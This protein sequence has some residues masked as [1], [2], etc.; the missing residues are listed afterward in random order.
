MKSRND[1]VASAPS[2]TGPST[3]STNIVASS[4]KVS[5]PS[6]TACRQKQGSTSGG[7][8]RP[9]AMETS[10]QSSGGK[11][12]LLPLSQAKSATHA[13]IATAKMRSP[14]ERATLPSST[15]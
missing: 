2:D 13:P 15:T 8:R 11:T 10:S 1:S 6:E 3:R 12:A 14:R 5:M 7:G 9:A 4:P